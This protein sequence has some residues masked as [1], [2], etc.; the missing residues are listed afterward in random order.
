MGTYSMEKL[1]GDL[2]LGLKF[3]KLDILS[4]S[5]INFLQIKLG[6]SR[7]RYLGIK[8]LTYRIP[9]TQDNKVSTPPLSQLRTK[10]YGF[11]TKHIGM[12]LLQT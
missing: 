10:S 8:G 1:A 12:R 2:L 5:F 7:S 3:V 11:S 6:E 4:I 9:D